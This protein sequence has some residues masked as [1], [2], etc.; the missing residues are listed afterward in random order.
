MPDKGCK[1]RQ[2]AVVLAPEGDPLVLKPAE[3]ADIARMVDIAREDAAKPDAPVDRA[4]VLRIRVTVEFNSPD[5]SLGNVLSW[6]E[7]RDPAMIARFESR[8]QLLAYG[9]RS[10]GKTRREMLTDRPDQALLAALQVG[11]VSAIRGGNTLLSARWFGKDVRHLTD[12][13]RFRRAE[14]IHE[15][16][17]PAPITCITGDTES[18]QLTTG[19]NL[20]EE[21]PKHQGRR[22]RSDDHD[23][24]RAGGAHQNEPK[25]KPRGPPATER[26]RVKKEMRRF[27]VAYLNAM[28]DVSMALEFETSISTARRARESLN[29]E[30]EQT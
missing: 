19:T 25:D 3:I 15:F 8:R 6:I 11:R 29:N 5:W 28:K 13:L 10:I 21:T 14:I 26:E 20:I 12:N 30:P 22:D 4:E 1:Q 16:P 24:P 17:A 18:D 7:F 23:A 27:T 9:I 2:I